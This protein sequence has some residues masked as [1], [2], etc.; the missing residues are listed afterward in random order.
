MATRQRGWLGLI[1]LVLAL[2]IV[3]LLAR[4]ILREYGLAGNPASAA[5]HVSVPGAPDVEAAANVTPKNA[6]ARARALQDEVRKDAADQEK[7]IDA[8]VS[9][10]SK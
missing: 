3:A 7:R 10:A 5:K 9:A 6:L 1:G 4:T 2:V 8:A